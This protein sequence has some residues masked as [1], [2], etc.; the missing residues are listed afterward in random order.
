MRANVRTPMLVEGLKRFIPRGAKKAAKEFWRAQKL[1]SGVRAFH[2]LAPG[3]APSTELIER[4]QTGWGNEDYSAGLAYIEEILRQ[5][6]STSGP[7]L[8]CGSG[9]TTLILGLIAG[10]RGREVWALEHDPAWHAHVSHALA[11]HGI[12]EVRLCLAPLHEYGSFSWYAPAE[13]LPRRFGLV[14]C[15]GPPEIT[16]GG[17]YGLLPVAGDRMSAGSVIL[18]DDA[19]RE[20]EMGVLERWKS[21]A[22]WNFDVRGFPPVQYAVV[23]A[24]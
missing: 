20:S 23:R 2:A 1:S 19:S 8:E 10:R 12:A 11:R 4:I 21:E 14:V 7:V 17:R 13:D 18:L 22:G 15:D 6:D 5:L 16:P 3:S 24:A 9:L